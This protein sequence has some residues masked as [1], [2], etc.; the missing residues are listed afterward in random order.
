MWK[1]IAL[2]VLAFPLSVTALIVF[3]VGNNWRA[4]V[5]A[6]GCTFAICLF[7][8]TVMLFFIRKLSLVDVFL[9]VVFSV[10]WSL[11][12]TPLSLGTEIF[13]APTAIGSGLLLTVCLWRYYHNNSI[14]RYWLILPTLIYV[15]EMLPINIPGPIDDYFSFGGDLA[16]TILFFTVTSGQKQLAA[17]NR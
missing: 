16:C 7:A 3:W 9:P 13:T 1:S 14:G 12:L 8:A 6:A 11:V 4:G 10:A 15:Y 17:A 2:I 5:A